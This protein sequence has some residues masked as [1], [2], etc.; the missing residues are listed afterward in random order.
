V[1]VRLSNRVEMRTSVGL[2]SNEANA[3]NMCLLCL[4]LRLVCAPLVITSRLGLYGDELFTST[5]L[6][7]T[8]INS[9]SRTNTV[10]VYIHANANKHPLP[11]YSLL[12]STT[13]LPAISPLFN[14]W[15]ASLN[16]LSG[17]TV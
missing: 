5:I 14:F 13:A 7:R 16:W 2:R 1:E 12:K 9:S 3:P 6:L 15:T 10:Y 11:G 17:Y 8:L 4:H